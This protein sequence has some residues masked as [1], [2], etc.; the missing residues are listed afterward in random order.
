M[1]KTLNV[2]TWI[3]QGILAIIL[4]WAGYTKLF[5]PK[6]TLAEMWSWTADNQALVVIAGI[7][8]ILGG[9]GILLP[10]LLKMKLQLTF[11]AAIGIALLMITAAIFHISRGEL[12]DIGINLFVLLLAGFVIYMMVKRKTGM[13]K[14]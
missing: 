13:Q 9:L 1:T 14:I 8:D 3:V 5:T 12:S 11:Y 6:E 10:S 4:L 7:F 2:I